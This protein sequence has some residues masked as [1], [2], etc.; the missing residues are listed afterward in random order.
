MKSYH[1]LFTVV[2]SFALAG[3]GAFRGEP[4]PAGKDGVDGKD[5]APG[6]A[7]PAGAP[8]K[9]GLDGADGITFDGTRLR[10]RWYVGDDG[11]KSPTGDWFDTTTNQ[12]CSYEKANDGAQ[13]CLPGHLSKEV[14]AY[15]NYGIFN[16]DSSC[17]KM[18]VFFEPNT[19][20]MPPAPDLPPPYFVTGNAPVQMYWKYGAHLNAQPN[21]YTVWGSDMMCHAETRTFNPGTTFWD[22]T[23]PDPA[24]F[25]VATIQ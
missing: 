19:G 10:A 8:G 22:L 6:P 20:T 17:T 4:G 16:T 15:Y 14:S 3:C 23:L 25:V 24:M 7:G 1:A 9:N 13:R 18:V 2:T 21:L 5:G 11:S 12:P